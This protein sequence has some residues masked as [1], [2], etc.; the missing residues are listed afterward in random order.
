MI[1][2]SFPI[3]S[4]ITLAA[5][6]TA[7]EAPAPVQPP[8]PVSAP[9]PAVRPS[10]V[11][12]GNFDRSVR[13]EDD[14]YHFINGAWLTKTEI[15][16]DKSNYGAF[17]VLMDGAEANLRAIAQEAAAAGAVAGTDQQ[18]IGD[19]YSS[20]LDEARAEQLG[21]RPLEAELARVEAIKD[22]GQLL[23]Y[24]ARAQALGIRNFIDAAVFAD[25]KNPDVNTVWLTQSGFGLPERDYYFATDTRFKEI[26]AAYQAHIAKVFTLAGRKDAERLA[27]DVLALETRL[28]RASWPAV[29]MREIE[30]LYN[31]FDVAGA[32]KA[33][34][35][36]DWARWLSALG[37]PASGQLVVGQPDYFKEV[38]RA[39]GD[40]PLATW[41]AYLKLRVIESYSPY[42]SS[43]FVQEDFEFY[44]HTLSGTP[45][46][47]PRWKRAL[48]EMEVSVGD[49]LGKEYVR[50]HFPP[51][52][53]QRMDEL[54]ANLLKAFD[55]G[56]ADLEWMGPET[57]KEA[58]EKIRHF[59]VKV[60]YPT[61]WK[62][63]QG[64]QVRSDDLVGNVMRAREVN[65]Q[66]QLA[67]IGK[68]VDRTE[69]GM[70]PQTVNAYY[71]PLANEIVFPAAILQPPFFD[72]N[73]DDA[74][75]YGGIGAVIGHEISHGFDDQGRK[76]DG[77]GTLRDW[78]TDDDNKRFEA[79]AGQL[80]KQYS[81]FSPLPGKY[82]NGQLT[83]GENI[84]DLS[85]L[86]VAH[87]AYQIALD[88][89]PAP[90]LDGFTGDQ[91]FFIGW[92]QVW[93][94]K[95]RDDE[96]VKRLMTD[97]HSPSE[98]RCNG[99]VRNMPAF[100]Q[101]FAVKPGDGLYLPAEQQVRI[102]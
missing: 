20:Y 32:T 69:W 46:L 76:F 91:R 28:A 75:N 64:L 90:V 87:R 51:E 1:R 27:A 82:V 7:P 49:L 5:C 67:K 18:L 71:N 78:W 17:T 48:D 16:G 31:P 96:M 85:G 88:G 92:A 43:P 89:Q 40:V 80:V 36:I 35:G 56:I 12:L 62:D 73:A 14:L 70:T 13:P 15:P 44:G 21:L 102:W 81:A 72:M 47:K 60:G 79:R 50:R 63:Y 30:K 66:R 2:W 83:L 84:G 97:P 19:F 24:L 94:R 58:E 101:A 41:R 57:R 61:K 6:A 42:L 100:Q 26:R 99:I 33:T 55:A 23:D 9:A 3:A 34:P 95:F 93:P 77:K 45:Q 25:A 65:T 52:A 29:R 54:V 86:A 59:T 4:L 68:P 39:L 8:A 11:T 38:G 10:G 74:V 98:Y 37:V 22:R 53:K